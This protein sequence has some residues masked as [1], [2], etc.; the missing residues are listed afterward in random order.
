MRKISETIHWE[1]KA[2]V[3]A[4]AVVALAILGPFG[5]Y[6]QMTFPER[7]VYWVMMAT[8]ISFFMHIAI[9]IA[10]ASPG[11]AKWPRALRIA[12]GAALGALP[13]TAV[14]IFVDGVFRSKGVEVENFALV[15]LQVTFLGTVLGLVEFMGWQRALR[16]EPVRVRTKFHKRLPA[17]LGDDI[18]SLSMQD[19]YA[20]VTTTLGKHLVLIRLND[21]VSELGGLAG[22]RIHRSHWVARRH[23]RKLER[24]GRKTLI[25]LSDQRKL[26]V[27][28]TYAGDV[29]RIL[30]H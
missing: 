16:R 20:E 29:A 25:T 8:G 5:T 1:K 12:I 3:F 14:V 19:H 13:G 30:E 7:F 10:I 15:W 22:Q 2:L 26:P 11:L 21:A 28:T 23:M 24:R 4:G 18:I 9:S 17:E 27:S 6:G